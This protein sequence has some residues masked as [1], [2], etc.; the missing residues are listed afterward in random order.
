MDE[1]GQKIPL[2]CCAPKRQVAPDPMD[3]A[4]VMA[5]NAVAAQ[6]GKRAQD[7]TNVA[8]AQLAQAHVKQ[9]QLLEDYHDDTRKAIA[10]R[11]W[12]ARQIQQKRLWEAEAAEAEKN[13]REEM[14]QRERDAVVQ[15]VAKQRAEVARRAKEETIKQGEVLRE[16]TAEFRSSPLSTAS[17]VMAESSIG[18][19]QIESFPTN[20]SLTSSVAKAVGR[21]AKEVSR[22]QAEVLAVR[23]DPRTQAD[24]DH[25]QQVERSIELEMERISALNVLRAQEARERRLAARKMAARRE[26]ASEQA[27]ATKHAEELEER[28]RKEIHL[29]DGRRLAAE[30]AVMAAEAS[31]RSGRPVPKPPVTLT[32]A[33]VRGLVERLSAPKQVSAKT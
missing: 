19:S 22:I 7:Q 25:L 30:Q 10:D 21:P 16:W 20:A 14:E 33:R 9:R 32:R 11:R 5:A 15:A 24:E 6:Q 1:G 8:V 27:W 28:R 2:Q 3:R 12:N 17:L 26:M 4:E 13:R 23:P 18:I 31:R 29:R